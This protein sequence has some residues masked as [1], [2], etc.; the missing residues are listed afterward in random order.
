MIS[1]SDETSASVLR[2]TSILQ[3][4][5]YDEQSLLQSLGIHPCE[6]YNIFTLSDRNTDPFRELTGNIWE[7]L[8]ISIIEDIVL[9]RGTKFFKRRFANPV[10]CE[11]FSRAFLAL[12]KLFNATGLIAF[13]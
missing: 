6:K 11:Y 8:G 13:F 5:P 1:Q 4:D 9:V 3:T 10:I 7:H 12:E 2:R